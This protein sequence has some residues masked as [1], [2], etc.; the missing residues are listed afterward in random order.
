MPLLALAQALA[1]SCSLSPCHRAH[2]PPA[3]RLSSLRSDQPRLFGN[4]IEL[5][6]QEVDFD[7]QVRDLPRQ[8]FVLD[9]ELLEEGED[10]FVGSVVVHDGDAWLRAKQSF[11]RRHA[12]GGK[13]RISPGRAGERPEGLILKARKTPRD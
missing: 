5:V 11:R 13:A 3:Q 10:L 9:D 1:L 2:V 12:D 6:L 8:F 7:L 4:G